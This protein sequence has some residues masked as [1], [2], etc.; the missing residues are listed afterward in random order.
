LSGRIILPPVRNLI[1]S[2]RAVPFGSKR[3]R[4]KKRRSP[5]PIGQGGRRT[6]PKNER[7][8]KREETSKQEQKYPAVKKNSGTTASGREGGGGE[9]SSPF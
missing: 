3:E 8:E 5:M 1:E 2:S 7:E 9:L 6:N 4:I